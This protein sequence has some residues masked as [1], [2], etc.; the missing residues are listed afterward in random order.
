MRR[1]LLAAAAILAAVL[2]QVTVL[3]NVPFPGGAGPDLVLVVVVAMAL[4]SGPRDGAII[5]FAAGL[6]L[7]IAPPASNLLG[8]S[9]LV[10][11]LVGYGC[12]RLRLVLERSAW[13]PLA[14]VA[15]GAAAGEALYAL[16]GL[17][18]GDPDVTWQAVR[19]VLPAAVFYDLLISPFVL[20]AVAWLGG[21]ARWGP[22][23][24]RRA[25]SPGGNWPRRAAACW[26]AWRRPV[27]RSATPGRAGRRGCG[28]PPGTAPTAGSA[29]AGNALASQVSRPAPGW[30]SAARRGCGCAAAWPAPRR[31]ASAAKPARPLT[32]VHLRLG[33]SAA[34]RRDDRG[35]AAPGRS[36]AGRRLRRPRPEL[37]RPA[38]PAAR[39]CAVRRPVGPGPGAAPQAAAAPAEAGQQA[40]QGRAGRWRQVRR[41]A[42]AG[43]AGPAAADGQGLVRERFRGAGGHRRRRRVARPRHGSGPAAGRANRPRRCAPPPRGSGGPGRGGSGPGAGS[44]SA[45][46]GEPVP[47][48]G[49][50]HGGEGSPGS[51]RG[52]GDDSGGTTAPGRLVR[53]GGRAAARAGRAAV[54]PAGDD[55]R[56]LRER[57]H[58]GPGQN[59]DRAAGAGPDPGRHRP[60]AGEQPH[61]AGGLGEPRAGLAAAGR[62]HRRT[63]PAGPAC[64]A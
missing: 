21:Y 14:G 46:P 10:F 7:D 32:T 55:R 47:G 49:P 63:A 61:R 42:V 54:V 4:A 19:Q 9:A 13:L 31:R 34:P 8:Q 37:G 15:V 62:G 48:C 41:P 64:S 28:P 35:P 25:C 36:R 39:R 43:P 17:I 59:G 38:R 1:A 58:P 26:Q 2:I 45:G 40:R 50:A 30:I 12:G 18:F 24:P 27:A 3:N 56:E 44:A 20:Y 29:A 53:R 23:R 6:A 11:C 33:T 60:A 5:G 16:V 51:A 52:D 22:D 57:G